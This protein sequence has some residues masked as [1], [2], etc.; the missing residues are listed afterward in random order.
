LESIASALRNRNFDQAVELSRS[1]LPSTAVITA[2]YLV[3]H[4]DFGWLGFGGNV[5]IS[6]DVVTIAPRDSFRSRVY[7]APVGL[8]LTLESGTFEKV[9]FNPKTRQIRIAL[10]QAD[11]S[12]QLRVSISSNRQESPK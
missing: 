12:L 5:S 4:A 1:A 2:T 3:K 9:E 7:V 10:A 8:W 6:G 11:H